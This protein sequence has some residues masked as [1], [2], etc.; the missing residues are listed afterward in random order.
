M[1]QL[2]IGLAAI[3]SVQFLAALHAE[4]TADAKTNICSYIRNIVC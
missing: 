2:H 4:M 1:H 3:H